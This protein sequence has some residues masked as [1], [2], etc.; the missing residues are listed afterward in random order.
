M[1]PDRVHLI[2]HCNPLEPDL[3][4]FGLDGAEEYVEFVRRTLP[5]PLRLTYNLDLL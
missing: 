2:A 5:A 4:R 1:T 3:G